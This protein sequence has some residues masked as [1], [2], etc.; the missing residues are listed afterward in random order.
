MYAHG[1]DAQGGD[2]D[3]DGKEE[4][5]EEPAVVDTSRS[6]RQFDFTILFVAPWIRIY[7]RAFDGACKTGPAFP[8]DVPGQNLRMNFGIG[9]GYCI[10]RWDFWRK[11]LG[12]IS[13]TGRELELDTERIAKGCLGKMADIKREKGLKRET[14]GLSEMYA[15]TKCV[16]QT[17]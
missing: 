8:S 13:E 7:G 6:A 11:R 16:Y 10:E 15:A 17:P 2:D 4:E 12:E 1:E 9:G 3:V 14:E 5:D